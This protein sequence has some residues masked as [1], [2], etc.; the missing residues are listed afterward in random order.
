MA[1]ALNQ[2]FTL[3]RCSA[4]QRL[5]RIVCAGPAPGRVGGLAEAAGD[6]EELRDE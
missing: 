5:R 6:E 2:R 3:V 4:E 1:I